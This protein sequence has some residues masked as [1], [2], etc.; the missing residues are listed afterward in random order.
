MLHLT[1]QRVEME[2]DSSLWGQPCRIM[3]RLMPGRFG[4]GKQLIGLSTLNSR[5]DY[6]VIRVDSR[7]DLDNGGAGPLFIEHLDDILLALEEHFGLAFCE[8]GERYGATPNYDGEPVGCELCKGSSVKDGEFPNV[9]ADG[10][11]EWFPLDRDR[12]L[13]DAKG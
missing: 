7:W 5:P 13:H 3:P 2:Q 10:G 6:Y 4:D 1:K 12:V 9:D 8:C 11:C